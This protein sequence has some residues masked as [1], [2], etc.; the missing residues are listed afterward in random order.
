MTETKHKLRILVV[1]DDLN[2][3]NTL[4]AILGTDGHQCQSVNSVEEAK[5]ALGEKYF[6][7]ILS[8]VRMPDQTGP[9]LYKWV[10]E[11]QPN[12][13]FI[14]MTAYTSSEVIEEAIQSG[15][16]TALQKPLDINSILHFFSKLNQELFAAVICQEEVVCELISQVLEGAGS[17]FQFQVYTTIDRFMSD[18]PARFRLVFIDVNR[19]CDHFSVKLEEM[20]ASLPSRT[21]VVLCDYQ[22]TFNRPHE[23]ANVNL[24]I[25]PREF[26]SLPKLNSILQNEILGI[27]REFLS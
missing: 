4:C 23:I 3:A 8:D 24:V 22:N 2:F 14:L 5:Q 25:L 20:F 7:C 19:P 15:V 10:K 18:Q 21:V 6:D 16:L 17:S 11:R 9:D 12:L 1:D 27:A 13:P 26:G